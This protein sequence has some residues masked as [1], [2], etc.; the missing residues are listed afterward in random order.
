MIHPMNDS[1]FMS[2]AVITSQDSFCVSTKV[3]AVIVMDGKVVSTGANNVAVPHT[4]R[5][6][7]DF[8][9]NMLNDEGKLKAT[10]RPRHSSWSHDNEIHAELRAVM[11]AHL[12]GVVL[13]N[14]TLYTTLNPCPNC[15]KHLELYAAHGAI[16]RVV[17]LDKYD[18]GDDRWILS[19][20]K[21]ATIDK[22]ERRDLPYIDFGKIITSNNE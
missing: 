14:A 19:V 21:Y 15:A 17:Y 8:C 16:K 11:N 7:S 22:M 18:R 10:E 1:H 3:G 13:K 9:K 2:L 6:C 12:N 5:K 20:G 4:G